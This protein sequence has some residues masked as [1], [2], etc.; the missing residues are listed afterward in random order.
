MYGRGDVPEGMAALV[1]G[2]FADIIDGVAGLIPQV[3]VH[4]PLLRYMDFCVRDTDAVAIPECAAL[5]H[6]L[7]LRIRDDPSLLGFFLNPPPPPS[8]AATAGEVS[9]VGAE[10]DLECA[11]FRGLVLNVNARDENAVRA[12]SGILAC[13]QIPD[14]GLT[15]FVLNRSLLIV[16]LVRA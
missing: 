4:R 13:L 16:A 5:L 11:L 7:A 6:V 14:A 9:E 3:G 1:L 12:R 2:F 10:T 15:D 8:A